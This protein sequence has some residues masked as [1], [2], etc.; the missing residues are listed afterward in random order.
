MRGI[1]YVFAS[2]SLISLG[3][4]S[5]AAPPSAPDRPVRTTTIK[6]HPAI[7]SVVLTGHIRAREEI[8]LAFQ[9]DGK[10]TERPVKVGDRVRLNQVVARLDP[11]DQQNA[12]H[13]NEADVS[14]AQANLAQANNNESRLRRNNAPN[15][16]LDQAVQ[17]VKVAQAQVDAAQA[18][19]KIAQNRLGYT[20]LTSSIAGVVI[21]TGAEPGEIVRAG[22][23]VVVIA[24]SNLKDAVFNVPPQLMY[25]KGVSVD[26]TVEVTLS[27]NKDISAKGQIREIAPG[28]DA[29]TRTIEVK[30]ALDDPP[31]D[32]RLGSSVTGRVETPAA[33]IIEIPGSALT[34]ANGLPAA[35]IV[36]PTTKTVSLRSVRVA[37]YEPNSVIIAQGLHEGDTVVTAGVQALRPGQKVRLLD[38]PP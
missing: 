19:L 2:L 35:W 33:E 29:A 21:A 31:A 26:S 10:L 36:D 22:Q 27:E 9:I 6:P 7:D 3:A 16:Q 18:K 8:K 25:V 28:T 14:A 15:D 24:R 32:M 38:A 20:E 4:C 23:P 17:Q 11:Q 1:A 34:E 13:A 5:D 12:L 37:R 30:I